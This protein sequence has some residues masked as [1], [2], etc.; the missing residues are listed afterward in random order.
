MQRGRNGLQLTVGDFSPQTLT[1]LGA[2]R[3]QEGC[4]ALGFGGGGGS[5]AC[6]FECVSE[7]YGWRGWATSF[8]HSADT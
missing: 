3:D 7:V 4:S 5:T 6:V 1:S 2:F 8:P